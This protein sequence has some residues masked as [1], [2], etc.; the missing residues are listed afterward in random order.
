[1]GT[2]IVT[3]VYSGDISY[4]AATSSPL[5]VTSYAPTLYVANQPIRDKGLNAI[6]AGVKS[7]G[8]ISLGVVNLDQEPE[9]GLA[10][11]RIYLSSDA[12]VDASDVL[13]GSLKRRVSLKPKADVALTVPLRIPANLQVGNYH[14]LAEAVNPAGRVSTT[15]LGEGLEVQ[16]P[17]VSLDAD[18]RAPAKVSSKP[19]HLT[20]SLADIG[21]APADGNVKVS[22]TLVNFSDA[23]DSNLPPTVSPV[24]LRPRR[25]AVIHLIESMPAGLPPGRF[26]LEASITLTSVSTF[27]V[28]TISFD[29]A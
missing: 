29:G 21:D 23:T 3:V 11:F 22:L 20:I 26:T 12:D 19:F 17:T 18:L 14:L 9:Q 7:A 15:D 5:S 28:T 13:L 10:Q 6:V 1:M 25:D 27:A 16:A 2:D 4:V 24:H 8:S